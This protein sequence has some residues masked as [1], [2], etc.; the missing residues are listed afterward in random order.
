MSD[1]DWFLKHLEFMM[2][3][4]CWP[5]NVAWAATPYD[6]LI[7]VRGWKMANGGNS[8]EYAVNSL[9]KRVKVCTKADILKYREAEKQHG[10][11]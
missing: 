5:P 9:G 6:F 4:L 8:E 3:V 10:K 11:R 2:G 7:A 1:S